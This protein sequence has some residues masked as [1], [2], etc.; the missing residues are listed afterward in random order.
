MTFAALAPLRD[1]SCMH[2][3][4]Q[5]EVF[6]D[7]LNV[8]GEYRWDAD[9][10]A[11]TVTFTSKAD[12]SHRIV[13]DAELIASIAPGPRSL[14]WGWSTPQGRVDGCGAQ[15]RMYGERYGIREL[16]ES[17]VPFPEGL[18]GDLGDAVGAIAHQVGA[19][20]ATVTGCSPTLRPTLMV[21]HRPCSC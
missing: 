4:L 8:L 14:L 5:Q 6:Y 10:F 13:V 12:R 1:Y 11:G 16:S 20:I 9:T 19:V 2:V 7:R 21:D 3:V 15:L 17:E 18:T